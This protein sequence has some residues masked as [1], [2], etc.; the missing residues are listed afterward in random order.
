LNGAAERLERSYG[1]GKEITEH[2]CLSRPHPVSFACHRRSQMEREFRLPL[3][4]QQGRYVDG[5]QSSYLH[6]LNDF[7]RLT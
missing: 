5:I 6:F 1:A 3:K 2:F 7:L 4:R